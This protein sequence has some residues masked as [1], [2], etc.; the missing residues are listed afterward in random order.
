MEYVTDEDINKYLAHRNKYYSDQPIDLVHMA[1]WFC[2]S[3]ATT[4]SNNLLEYMEF[5]AYL[6]MNPFNWERD[7][8]AWEIRDTETHEEIISFENFYDWACK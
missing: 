2:N 1:N 7:S 6:F 4:I 8:P 3:C 5:D